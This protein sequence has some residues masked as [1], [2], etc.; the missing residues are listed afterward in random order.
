M[1]LAGGS[2]EIARLCDGTRSSTQVVEALA[3]RHPGEPGLA[4]D[5]HEFIA[6]MVKL[7]AFELRRP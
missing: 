3:A 2:C 7:S 4:D 6:E 1:K 5:V